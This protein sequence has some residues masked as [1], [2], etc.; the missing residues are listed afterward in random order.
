MFWT[1]SKNVLVSQEIFEQFYI[2]HHDNYDRNENHAFIHREDDEDLYNGL[3]LLSKHKPVTQKEIEFKHLVNRKEINVIGSIPKPYDVVFISYQEPNADVNY[4]RLLEKR[5]DAKRVHGVKGIHQ[6]HI[7][8]AKLCDTDMFWIVDGDAEI[9]DDFDFD[10]KVHRWE[11]DIVHVWRSQN[12]INDLVYGYGGIKLFPRDLTINMDITKPDMT[13][14]ISNR[15]RTVDVV[16]NITAFNTDPF[17]TWKSAF[18][19]CVKLSSNIIDRQKQEETY[20]RLNTWCTLGNDRTF[21]DLAISGA[22]FG[23]KYGESNK[24]NTDALRLIND[25]DWLKEQFYA[26]NI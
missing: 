21:G 14:S 12:P 25:F 13:T 16:S 20:I 3:W 18:R 2:S 6:A 7:A 17:N 1:A 4:N 5:P 8:A 9:V 26:S 23:R 11:K 22:N 15:F 19:E 10:F 24:G